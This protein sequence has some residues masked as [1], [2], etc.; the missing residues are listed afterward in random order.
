MLA[1]RLLQTLESV[2]VSELYALLLSV[3]ALVSGHL[4]FVLTAIFPNL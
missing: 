4:H 2:M 3:G 1:F